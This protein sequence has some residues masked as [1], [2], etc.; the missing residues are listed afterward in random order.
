VEGKTKGQLPH[1][2]TSAFGLAA[3]AGLVVPIAF[4]NLP[5]GIALP[6]F[7]A[8]NTAATLAG[9]GAVMFASRVFDAV[10]DPL[11]GYLSDRTESRFGS[12]KPW[13]AF[14][15]VVCVVALYFLFNPAPEDGIGHFA[16]W[17]FFY[18]LGFTFIDIPHKAWGIEIGR[19]NR[20]RSQISTYVTFFTV[21]GSLIFWL[22]PLALSR[23]SGTTAITG[24]TFTA[25]SWMFAI[26]LPLLVILAVTFAPNGSRLSS[27]KP[28]MLGMFS[29]VAANRPSWFF[30]TAYGL[31]LMGNGV[32]TAVL[33]IFMAQYMKLEAQFPFL[34]IAYFV[35]Q[36]ICVPVWLRLV[37]R[38]GKRRCWAFSWIAHPIVGLSVLLIE[39]G[40]SAFAPAMALVLASGAIAAGALIM[41]MAVLGDVIDYGTLKTGINR[42]ANYF[43]F[44]N[45]LTKLGLA[46]GFG[47]GFPLL[48]AF[49]F[50]WGEPVTGMA[51]VGLFVCYLGI[52]GVLSIV[53]GLM[54]LRFPLHADRHRIV[55]R[56]LEQRAARLAISSGVS[57]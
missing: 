28:T 30:F 4:V 13:V 14:G 11:I 41:P 27:E 37:Y 56:R 36:V 43:A 8:Q 40:A 55:T 12:R 15:A 50:E 38:F 7:Y 31:W 49:G 33:Y 35:T 16:I 57:P 20:E 48:G 23:L 24:S 39:P 51:K 22:M 34:M 5:L 17:S 53:A 32:F 47:L 46:V 2:T 3:Y 10:T 18:Y 54:V 52:P 1:P 19:S 9:I 21:V 44:S 26:L 45:I 42:S 25:I 29:A 6:S